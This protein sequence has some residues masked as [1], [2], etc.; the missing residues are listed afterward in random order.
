M[1]WKR[2]S[3]YTVPRRRRGRL[4]EEPQIDAEGRGSKSLNLEIRVI[5]I[6]SWRFKMGGAA[7]VFG[8]EEGM[9]GTRP[10][11]EIK[12]SADFAVGADK[13]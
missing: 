2:L 8:A 11:F 13:R 5:G 12:G 4:K 3:F 10:R 7:R 9:R 6:A 1:P